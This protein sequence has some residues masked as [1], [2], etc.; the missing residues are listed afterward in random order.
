LWWCDVRCGVWCGERADGVSSQVLCHLSCVTS[1]VSPLLCHLSCVT[2]LVSPLLMEC[3]FKSCVTSLVSADGVSS[4][5][6]CVTSLVSPLLCLQGSLSLYA[7]EYV[8]V[9]VC[10]CLRLCVCTCVCLCVCVCLYLFTPCKG[11]RKPKR[12]PLGQLGVGVWFAECAC[13]AFKLGFHTRK[14]PCVVSWAVECACPS[15][16]RSST[17]RA[18]FQHL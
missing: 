18:P 7:R 6:S 17:L 10:V 1:L 11:R 16:S 3:P 9:C 12:A 4:Q 8:W 13:Q 14:A 5:V 15:V 2:S